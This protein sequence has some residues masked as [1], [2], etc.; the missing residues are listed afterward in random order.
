MCVSCKERVTPHSQT[1]PQRGEEN[2]LGS[3]IFLLF[4]TPGWIF[5]S[6]PMISMYQCWTQPAFEYHTQKKSNKKSILFRGR[7]C[8]NLPPAVKAVIISLT[9]VTLSYGLLITIDC[10]SVPGMDSY[11]HS[12][13]ITYRG[14]EKETEDYVKTVTLKATQSMCVCVCVC[15]GVWVGMGVQTSNIFSAFCLVLMHLSLPLDLLET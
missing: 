7:K 5:W 10:H 1:D 12:R 6:A 2:G 3:V 15:G 11:S 8:C 14:R 4:L 13:S 9:Q